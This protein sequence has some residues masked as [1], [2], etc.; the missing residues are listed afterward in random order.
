MGTANS[1]RRGSSTFA[2]HVEN[3]TCLIGYEGLSCER[4]AKGAY[5][6]FFYKNLTLANDIDC[7]GLVFSFSFE[8]VDIFV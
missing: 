3:A 7:I 4:C 2:S 1:T 8:I 6:F 5:L